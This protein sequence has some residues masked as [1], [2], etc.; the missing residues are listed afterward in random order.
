MAPELLRREAIDE[1]IDIFAF[2]FMAFEFLTERL[3]YD[4]TTNAAIML[5]R[6]N[7]EP[8]DPAVIKPQLSE[9]LC[10]IL[11]QLTAKK[12]AQRWAEMKTLPDA[13]RNVPVKRKK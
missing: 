6:I 5:Q 12:P 3:P 13:L 2:G 1:R 8:L 9:E 7:A 4:A 11:R 10:G